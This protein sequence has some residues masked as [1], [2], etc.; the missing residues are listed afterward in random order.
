MT[1]LGQT[2]PIAA[3]ARDGRHHPTLIGDVIYADKS[4]ALHREKVKRWLVGVNRPV[5][6]ELLTVLARCGSGAEILFALPFAQQRGVKATERAFVG[7]TITLTPQV[8][9]ARYSADWVA[10]RGGYRLA[11]EVDG[12]E[13]HQATEDQVEADY[14]RQRRIVACGYAVVRF[15]ARDVF[16]DATAAWRQVETIME[17]NRG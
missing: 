5:S 4:P 10:E 6:D 12:Y 13:Y 3:P 14:L 15:T 17:K 11:I 8:T 1:L 2:D 7:P 9:I 16:R